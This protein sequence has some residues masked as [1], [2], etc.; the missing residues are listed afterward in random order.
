[1]LRKRML[2]AVPAFCLVAAFLAGCGGTESRPAPDAGGEQA[3]S[4]SGPIFDVAPGQPVVEVEGATLT[5]GELNRR[6]DGILGASRG[7]DIPQEQIEAVRAR[8]SEQ[9]VEQFVRERVLLAEAEAQKIE[10]DT[11]AVSEAVASLTETLPEGISLEEAL[12]REGST[13]E[14]LERNVESS[15]KVRSLLEQRAASVP[16][17]TEAEIEEFYTNNPSYF[18]VSET[19]EARHVLIG[20]DADADEA[21]RREKAEEAAAI[22]KELVEG[23]DFAEV[24]K[25]RSDCP[26]AERGGDLGVFQRGQ[27]V[28]PFDQAAFSQEVGAIGPVVETEYGYH[29]IQV[30]AHNEPR[31]RTL[32]EAR[33][34]IE[35]YLANLKR[36]EA[37]NGYV[38]ELKGKYSVKYGDS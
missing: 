7:R 23:A 2:V 9:L 29:I 24:A 1:M 32:D 20:V 12:A 22:R 14:E 31:Q 11:A 25:A 8:L 38:E 6:V 3:V 10:V 28:E 35:Q 4:A 19:V 36:Q 34:D 30:A 37:V 13:R 18:E 21:A 5:R 27:M 15:L 16:E 33:A 26:S 17:I